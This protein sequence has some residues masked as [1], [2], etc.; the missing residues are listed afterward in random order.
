[1]GSAAP[2][3]LARRLGV[4]Y[5]EFAAL[6]DLDL[7]VGAGEAIALLGPNG[8]GKSTCL[9]ALSGLEAPSAGELVILGE[10]PRRASR[11]WKRKVGVLPE[12]PAL[13]DALS[14]EEH[15]RL[16]GE[17]YGLAAG[18]TAA[19]SEEILRLLGLWENRARFAAA[20][21]FGMRK[22]TALALALLHAPQVLLLDEPFEGL[23]PVSCENVLALLL[24]LR[25]RGVGILFTSHLIHYVERLATEAVLLLGG[26]TVWRGSPQEQEDLAARYFA[27]I[28]PSPLPPLHWI[29]VR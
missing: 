7:Q 27:A 18:E 6:E 4:R 9:K 12:D 24:Q 29:P 10:E 17:L 28:A 13:W 5:G 25:S 16:S 26:R 20:A 21:S 8:A 19:R 22:K 23:D 2:L 15:C 11:E 3:L 1:M 14:L